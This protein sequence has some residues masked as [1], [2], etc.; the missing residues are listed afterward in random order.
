M[1]VNTQTSSNVIVAAF[2]PGAVEQAIVETGATPAV[3]TKQEKKQNLSAKVRGTSKA[4]QKAATIGD[5]V[6]RIGDEIGHFSADQDIGRGMLQETI[7]GLLRDAIKAGL[8]VEML[9]APTKASPQECYVAL[10]DAINAPRLALDDITRERFAGVPDD[11][12]RAKGLLLGELKNSVRDNYLSRIR[13]FLKSRGAEPLDLFGNIAK[14]KS[15][16][17][18]KQGVSEASDDDEAE[19]VTARTVSFN[20]KSGT[21]ESLI[22]L[23][24]LQKFLNAWIDANGE[25]KVKASFVEMVADLRDEIAEVLNVK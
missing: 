3:T 20:A 23:P 22:G 8:T 19:R 7:E 13:N 25:G 14:A 18:T 10:V 11:V 17:A 16:A 4:N 1:A 15:K 6:Q 12:L 21:D 5:L 9:K 2:Q 24:A